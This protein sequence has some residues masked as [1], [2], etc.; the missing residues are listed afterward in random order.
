MFGLPPPPRCIGSWCRQRQRCRAQ[1]DC[2]PSTSCLRLPASGGMRKV[3]GGVEDVVEG[4]GDVILD[5]GRTAGTLKN[6]LFPKF[7]VQG[8]NLPMQELAAV[9]PSP[10][11]ALVLP[12]EIPAE[13]FIPGMSHHPS[14]DNHPK[15]VLTGLGAHYGTNEPPPPDTLA[16]GRQ[17][18]YITAAPM[19]VNRLGE[20][21]VFLPTKSQNGVEVLRPVAIDHSRVSSGPAHP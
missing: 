15:E 2:P 9:H 21:V 6:G 14:F 18:S 17:S 12:A 3:V 4:L 8:D 20:L 5:V 13:S 16:A 10:A 1:E 7:C 19:T 11:T